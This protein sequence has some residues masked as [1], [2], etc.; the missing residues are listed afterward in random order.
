MFLLVSA[1]PCPVYVRKNAAALGGIGKPPLVQ[2]S[3]LLPIQATDS[4]VKQRKRL[5]V[6]VSVQFFPSLPCSFRSSGGS[7]EDFFLSL[8][9]FF[10]SKCE[11]DV[12]PRVWHVSQS[13]SH[14]RKIKWKRWTDVDLSPISLE[15]QSVTHCANI[16]LA[17]FMWLL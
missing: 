8:F 11:P 16:T 5:A 7:E 10:S 4:L 3:W 14:R 17:R 1:P 9:L 12:K 2:C 6:E 15:S 13:T